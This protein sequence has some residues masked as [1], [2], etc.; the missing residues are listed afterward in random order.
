MPWSPGKWRVETRLVVLTIR[1][2]HTALMPQCAGTGG[3][4][5]RTIAASPAAIQWSYKN[6]PGG[7]KIHSSPHAVGGYSRLSRAAKRGDDLGEVGEEEDAV[8]P[9]RSVPLSLMKASAACQ[10]KAS[11]MYW[12]TGRLAKADC[13]SELPSPPLLILASSTTNASL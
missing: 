6:E 7:Y 2:D 13:V 1:I 4:R 3:R 5:F 10:R 11:E 12:E 9:R 8:P